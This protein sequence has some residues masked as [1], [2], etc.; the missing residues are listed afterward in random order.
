MELV[1]EKIRK[2]PDFPKKGIL[3]Y[4]LTPVMRD[5]I[6]FAHI[7]ES[8][9]E[10]FERKKVELVC[11][12]ESR[13]FI[14]GSALASDLG[15]GFIPVRKP[16]KLPSKTIKEEYNLEYGTDA[17]EIHHDAIKK[18]Q[19]VLMIDDV[20][21]TGGTAEAT[22]RLLRRAGADVIGAAFVLEI[23]ALEGRKRLDVESHVLISV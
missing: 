9:A 13:G 19:R 10:P 15:A 23:A 5:P 14:F 3:F 17:L 2:V 7:L 16:G 20:L 12:M 22:L 1:R 18:G 11:S 4:D 8:L 6:T 21:A